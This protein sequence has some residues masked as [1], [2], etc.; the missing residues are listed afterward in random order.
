M[1]GQ[2]D[3]A[4]TGDPHPALAL[5]LER[6]G[7][8]ADGQNAH[9]LRRAR[10]HRGRAGPGAPAHARGDEQHMAPLDQRADLIEHLFRRRGAN[11]R[12]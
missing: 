12:P 10:N 5:E 1:L 2:I 11:F 8:D 3:D 9:L 7:D 4:L 6:L